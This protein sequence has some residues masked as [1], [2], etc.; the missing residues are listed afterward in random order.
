MYKRNTRILLVVTIT[1]FSFLLCGQVSLNPEI[2]GLTDTVTLRYDASQGNQ[3]LKDYNGEIYAHTGLITD[4]SSHPGDWKYVVADWN[5]NDAR[6]KMT[7][8]D[9]NIWE[10]KFTISSLYGIP[11]ASSVV[12]L[13]FVFRS[14]DGHKTGKAEGNRDIIYYL[15]EPNF[16]KVAEVSSISKT[17]YPKWSQSA[18][19][20]EV[21]IRQYTKEGTFRAFAQHLTR[22]RQMGVDILWFMPIQP[23]GKLNRKGNLGSYY[24]ILDYKSINPEFGTAIDFKKLVDTAHSLGFRV[25]L[26]WV[27]NHTSWDHIWTQTNPEWYVKDSIGQ[28]VSPYDWTDVIKLDYSND[29]MRNAMIEAMKYWVE[30]MDIDG[31]RCDVAGEVPLD[32]WEKT[33]SQLEE[34]KPIWM[35]AEDADK[36]YLLNKAFNANYGWPLHHLMNEVAIGR[37]EAYKLIEQIEKDLKSYP[38]GSYP[39]HFITNHDENTWNGTEYERLM[40][41]V[42]AFSVF[43]YTIPGIPLI[44]SGQEAANS[45]R[46]A[47]F[48]KDEIDWSSLSLA[49]F[50]SKLNTLKHENKVLW[51]GAA[52]GD[53]A[54][55]YNTKSKQVVSFKRSVDGQSMVVLINLSPV[56]AQ[57]T[58]HME[59]HEGNY[60]EYFTGESRIFSGNNEQF[61]LKPWEYKVYFL[62]KKIERRSLGA[63]IR[64]ETNEAGLRIVTDMGSV[65]FQFLHPEVINVLFE[66][67][68]IDTPKGY[69]LLP[70]LKPLQA[71]LTDKG[72]Q[73][74]YSTPLLEV[75]I[76]KSDLGIAYHYKNRLLTYE[77]RTFSE[78]SSVALKINFKISSAEKITGG[79][80]R[81]LGMDRRGNRLRLYNKPSYGYETHADLMY[82][83][84]PLAISSNK[85]MVFFDNVADGYLDIA[86]TDKHILGFETNGGRWS[87]TVVTADSWQN[88][89]KNFTNVT[90]NQPL[91]PKWVLGNLSSRMGYKSQRQVEDVVQRYEDT[92]MPLDA[93]IFDLYWFGKDLKGT[94][95]NLDWY[96]DSFPYPEA[97][98]TKLKSKGIK[99]ILITEPFIIENT[100][101]FEEAL[102]NEILGKEKLGKPYLY[103]FYFG[104]TGL[105]DIFDPNA[106][107][108]FWSIYRYHT[109]RGVA[110]WWGDL[111]EPEVHP[112]DIVHHTGIGIN[113]HNAYGHEWA[114]LIYDGYVKDFPLTRPVIL[115]R[116]GFIGSQRYGLIPWS[117]DVNRTWGGLKPQVEISL[118]M[119][120]QGMGLMHSDLGGFAG[121]YRDAELYQRWLQYGVFQPIFRTHAQAEVPAEP[122]FWDDD[123]KD[124][125]RKY[126]HLRYAMLP[127]NYTLFWLNSTRGLPPMRPLFFEEDDLKLFNNSSEYLWGD[128]FLVSPITEKGLNIK[129]I[130]FPAKSKWVDYYTGKIY[131]GGRSYDLTVRPYDIPLFVRAGALIPMAKIRNSIDSISTSQYEIHYYPI[132]GKHISKTQLYDDDGISPNSFENG[133]YYL[134]HIT[135]KNSKNKLKFAIQ[136]EG[137]GWENQ[138]SPA[139]F[140]FVIHHTDKKIRKMECKDELGNILSDA[141]EMYKYDHKNR[142]WTIK[143]NKVVHT[144]EIYF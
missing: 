84:M 51:N 76:N 127:Y 24:S 12:A 54:P 91:P 96:R 46:L 116:A 10:L 13:T 141:V 4:Q 112:D 128:N 7:K 42:K 124:I 50:Y 129:K 74:I 32:F 8:V 72:D 14:A 139:I 59:G 131:K 105:I 108:W 114:K 81:V 55:I 57:T 95:G 17:P 33:R 69:A 77:T 19:I 66:Y 34:I 143:L 64:H 60:L 82:Y 103:D 21:N 70:D 53:F 93:I 56:D 94:L 132:L 88:L 35:L 87:Y 23:I 86:A 85:Y 16:Q 102:K 61:D 26:D 119:G 106:R 79:G 92:N 62:E 134:Y 1:A 135:C 133:Q 28:Y 68:N 15:R 49:D 123:T 73:I 25:I 136:Y 100:H 130:Y 39:M 90:G 107:K 122:V 5:K 30:E 63:Y 58:I 110:G 36:H 125:I 117:G 99:T 104:H 89:L 115:M 101:K 31:F 29:E 43:Y 118:T 38:T 6:L 40:D 47:F 140:D 111:G 65:T 18:N 80:L 22:L 120:L 45:K 52:G 9:D 11:P 27:A 142:K 97:M 121:D 138:P 144:L 98:M 37:T 83:S 41:G 113:L 75:R 2:P 48:E 126:I 71:R 137:Q 109:Q 78:S 20:Y 67:E 44:Y 3:G